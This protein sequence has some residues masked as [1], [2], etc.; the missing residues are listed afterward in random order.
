MFRRE[1]FQSFLEIAPRHAARVRYWDLAGTAPSVKNTD[2]DWAA[3]CKMSRSAQHPII[4]EDACRIRGEPLAVENLIVAVAAQDGPTVP[5]VIE[6]EPGASGK[7]L[8]DTLSRGRLARF[9]VYGD[10]PTGAKSTRAAVLSSRAQAGNVTLISG[11]W[12]EW[13]LNSLAAA[14]CGGHDDDAD[15]AS[16]AYNWLARYPNPPPAGA[17]S[18]STARQDSGA[19]LAETIL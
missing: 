2:P 8:V 3:G 15:A 17:H 11:P 7:I 6:Q 13:W 9:R 16:G 10:R 14:F 5:I 19:A 1:W 4:V 18:T 12:N